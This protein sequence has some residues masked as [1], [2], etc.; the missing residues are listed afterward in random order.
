MFRYVLS[1]GPTG[2]SAALTRAVPQATVGTS[3]EVL[4]LLAETRPVLL[5]VS[6]RAGLPGSASNRRTS[7]EVHGE[8]TLPS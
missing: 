3:L 7:L 4:R 8:G 5:M 2:A 1:P 6:Y